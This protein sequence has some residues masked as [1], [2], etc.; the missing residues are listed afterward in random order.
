[1]IS[2]ILVILASVLAETYFYEPFNDDPIGTRWII[3]KDERYNGSWAIEPRQ[4]DV[5]GTAEEGL[6]TK[7]PLAFHAISSKVQFEH[8]EG[9]FVIQYEVK[10]QDTPFQCGGAYIK[11]LNEEFEPERFSHKTKFVLMFGPDKCG[12]SE[13]VATIYRTKNPVSKFW[14]EHK[15]AEPP[16]GEYENVT[17]LYRL[18]LRQ[19]DTFEVLVDGNVESSGDLNDRT[20]F[21]P[22]FTPNATIPDYKDVKPLD[23]VDNETMDDPEDKKPEDWDEDAPETIP[24]MNITKP[25]DW[26]EEAPLEIVDTTAVK[27]AEWDDEEDGEWTAP[28]ISNPYCATHGCGQWVRP[29][30]KNPAYKGKW[31]AKQ[32]PNPDYKGEWKPRQIPNPYYFE[33]KDLSKIGKVFGVGIDILGVQDGV[34]F[35]SLY[36]GNSIEEADELMEEKWRPRYTLELKEQKRVEKQLRAEHR[37]EVL[38]HFFEESLSEKFNIL[39]DVTL[40]WVEDN[41]LIAGIILASV[42]VIVLVSVIACVRACSSENRFEVEVT[43][44]SGEEK[45]DG[46]PA[47]QTTEQTEESEETPAEEEKTEE[48]IPKPKSK[49]PEPEEPTTPHQ[50][51]GQSQVSRTPGPVTA[52][53]VEIED[54]SDEEDPKPRPKKAGKS[55]KRRRDE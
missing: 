16:R 23:W 18:V 9:D 47:Q 4:T 5:L 15:L 2:R 7:N 11:L 36:I 1:M 20:L 3:S 53:V 30:I 52:P 22:P 50:P 32:I 17:H 25:E 29:L 37:K 12:Y 54:D 43:E 40:D 21:S 34:M 55:S 33:A 24:N 35:S 49:S 48:T 26:D 44:H 41:T 39:R 8:T 10:H 45:R 6:V 42:L 19:N 13:K 28:I 46:E 38:S 51:R 27:P 31:T 14:D